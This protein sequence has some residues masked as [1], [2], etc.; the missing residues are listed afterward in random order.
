ML[1][2]FTKMHGCGNDFMVIDLVSQYSKLK[3]H[4]IPNWSDRHFGIGFDQLLIVE[5]PQ[6]PQA[7][8]RYRIFNADGEEVEQCGNGARCFALFVRDKQLTNKDHLIVETKGGIIELYITGNNEVTVDMG[9]PVL[10]PENIP[11]IAEQQAISYDL[12]VNGEI[13]DVSAISM[14]NPHSVTLVDD[15]DTANVETLGPQ[16]ESHSRFP[17]RTNAGFMQILSRSEIRLRVYER[18]AGE[19]LACGTGACAA[20]VAGRL[21]GLLDDTVTVHL[22]GGSLSITW[23]GDGEPVKMTGPCKKVF[24]G[25]IYL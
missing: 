7:D 2:K 12:D 8:F 14:G 3:P 4:L 23:A 16:I 15:V 10:K 25:R 22:P 11:F 13:L 9:I 19:T 6:S 18:G 5:P 20:V 24:E 17:Q 21:R 1:L